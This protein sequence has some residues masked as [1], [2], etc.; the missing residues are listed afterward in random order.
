MFLTS[1]QHRR[2][3]I[4]VQGHSHAEIEKVEGMLVSRRP[5]DLP[6]GM[7]TSACFRLG[8]TKVSK[9]GFTNFVYC[10]ITPAMSLPRIATSLC[11]LH[12]IL[13]GT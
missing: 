6:Q 1:Q 8:A 2:S 4:H 13:L 3:D 9:A 10:S 7:M 11:I 12:V 5:A